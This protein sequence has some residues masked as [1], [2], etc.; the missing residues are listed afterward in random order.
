[1]RSSR[2]APVL[3][4]VTLATAT[5]CGFGT[6]GLAFTNDDRV[7][8]TQP[9]DRERLRL[10][11]TIDWTVEDFGITQPGLGRGDDQGYF[12]V[13]V[14]RSPVPAGKTLAHV[15]RDDRSCRRDDGCP[16]ADYL[17]DR[18][19]YTTTRTRLVIDTLAKTARDG[20][21]EF[22]DV[23]VVLLDSDGRRIGESAWHVRFE[24]ERGVR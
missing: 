8:I 19:V 18:N 7:T 13:F 22:H 9:A 16:D 23:T 14:D 20:R 3:V 21:R 6:D 4:A 11:V 17:A 1:M 24:L 15:A 10:P 2:S 12:A 5:A